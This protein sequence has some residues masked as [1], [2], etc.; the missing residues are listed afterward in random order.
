MAKKKEEENPEGQRLAEWVII[1]IF[2]ALIVLVGIRL[3]ET[4]LGPLE[5]APSPKPQSQPAASP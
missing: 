1:I 3:H 5:Q 4:T 2:V